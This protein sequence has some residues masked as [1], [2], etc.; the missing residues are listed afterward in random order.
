MPR[1]S[2]HKHSALTPTNWAI[3]KNVWTLDEDQKNLVFPNGYYKVDAFAFT[4][5]V[6]TEHLFRDFITV[7]NG[8]KYEVCYIDTCLSHIEESISVHN[9]PGTR[10]SLLVCLRTVRATETKHGLALVRI[11]PTS[12]DLSDSHTLEFGTSK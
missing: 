12:F 3:L 1:D 2:Y 10:I 6:D 7:D 4:R 11:A 8:K 5:A 9:D